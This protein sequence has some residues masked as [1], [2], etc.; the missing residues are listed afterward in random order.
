MITEKDLREAIAECHGKRNPDA[1]TCVK[2]ASYY[3]ILDHITKEENPVPQYSMAASPYYIDYDSGTEFSKAVNGLDAW[4]V[5]KIMDELMTA[6]QTLYPRLYN[7]AMK[8]LLDL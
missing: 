3:S 7:G 5:M 6:L 1:S 4:D 8:K 2:L